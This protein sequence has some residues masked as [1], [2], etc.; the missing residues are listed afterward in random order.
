M[1]AL[2]RRTASSAEAKA[3][4][5]AAFL[6]AT[7]ALLAEGNAY[8]EMGIETIAQRAGFSRATFYAYFSDKRDLLFKLA[9]RA[10]H[11]L[12]ARAGAWL[13]V[14]DQADIREMLESLLQVFG[15]HRAVLGALVETATY[16]EE[17]ARLW[18]DMHDRFIDVAR[19]RIRR[20]HPELSDEEVA[21]Q[22][23]V[24]VWMTERTSYEHHVAPRASDEGLIAA[25]ELFWRTALT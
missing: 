2:S 4:T 21:G 16:D 10:T 13:E 7:T 11:D 22:A 12:Y 18:R 15:T 20:E 23:F 8:G 24:L 25:L 9:E 3:R 14:G 1:P 17:I 6:D 5:E 19:V